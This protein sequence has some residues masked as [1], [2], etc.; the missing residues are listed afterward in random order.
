MI[1]CFPVYR[2]YIR[3]NAKE[4]GEEDRRYISKAI[5]NAKRRNPTISPSIFDFIESLLL[6]RAL[7]ALTTNSAGSGGASSCGSSN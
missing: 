2:S 6:L 5:R 7:K 3:P 1:A 4:A